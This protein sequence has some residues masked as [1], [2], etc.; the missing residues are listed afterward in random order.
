MSEAA[1][2]GISFSS[3]EHWRLEIMRRKP[4][5]RIWRRVDAPMTFDASGQR[6]HDQA[7][8]L[9]LALQQLDAQLFLAAGALASRDAIV[10]KAG[11]ERLHEPIAK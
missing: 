4:E 8:L 6:L 5:Q 9:V 10:I 3:L 1:H 2:G 11:G 7:L